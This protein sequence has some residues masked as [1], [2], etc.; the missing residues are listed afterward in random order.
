MKTI[1]F[2]VCI[3][4]FLQDESRPH[5]VFRLSEQ[6]IRQG[7]NGQQ[8]RVSLLPWN[9]NW[10][11]FAE[12]IWLVGQEYDCTPAVNVYAYSWGVGNGAVELAKQLAKRSIGIHCLVSSDGVYR[13]SWL[14][15]WM[16]PRSMFSRGWTD[17]SPTIHLPASIHRVVAFHQTQNRPQGHRLILRGDEIDSTEVFS[18]D[19]QYMD[20]AMLFHDEAINEAAKLQIAISEDETRGWR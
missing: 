18:T 20:D 1:A 17:L 3:S 2:H 12:R 19:H 9:H 7:H 6:L 10:S 11:S 16:Q 4:G 8:S 15:D 13:V 5:G 14:P